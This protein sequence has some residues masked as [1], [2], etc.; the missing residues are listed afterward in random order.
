MK[1]VYF[2]GSITGGRDDADIYKLLIE[3][4]KER[5]VVL[6]EH[7][8]NESISEL[9]E[10]QLSDEQIYTR[11]VNWIKESDF[12]FAEVTHLSLGVGYEIGFA[13]AHGKPIFCFVNGTKVNRLSAMLTGN[14]NVECHVYYDIQEVYDFIDKLKV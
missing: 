1:K 12:V 7:I 8:G 11:D 14:K 4:L 9:G 6:T 5:F 10:Y 13:E 2:A 3:K